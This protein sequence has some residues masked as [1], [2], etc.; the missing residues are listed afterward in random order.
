[1]PA[2]RNVCDAAHRDLTAGLD[3]RDARLCRIRDNFGHRA[4]V[5]RQQLNALCVH[6]TV[7]PASFFGTRLLDFGFSVAGGCSLSPISGSGAGVKVN[8]MPF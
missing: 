5:E 7:A 1:M 8:A 6:W 3:D 4:V 2:R